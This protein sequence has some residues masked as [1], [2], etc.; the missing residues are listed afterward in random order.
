MIC[1]PAAQGLLNTHSQ[2]NT[3]EFKLL[4]AAGLLTQDNTAASTG[5]MNRS[6]LRDI[7][8]SDSKYPTDCPPSEA[9]KLFRKLGGREGEVFQ[10]KL[11]WGPCA[12]G[13]VHAPYDLSL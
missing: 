11:L 4:A 5:I 10:G 9:G 8:L 1:S 7:C 3:V 12:A 6:R 2:M 13:W